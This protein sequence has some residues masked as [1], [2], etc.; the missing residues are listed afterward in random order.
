MKAF[1]YI[2][3]EECSPECFKDNWY[4]VRYMVNQ[5]F[6]EATPVQEGCWQAIVDG[7]DVIGVAEPGSG[8]TLA[9]LLP[10]VLKMVNWVRLPIEKHFL[11]IIEEHWSPMAAQLDCLSY[12]LPAWFLRSQDS[13]LTKYEH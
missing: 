5:G 1:Y 12:W 8:K 9:F 3:G 11:H 2:V 13:V 6:I 7:Q 10:A 4:M